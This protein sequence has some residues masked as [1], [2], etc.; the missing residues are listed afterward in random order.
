MIIIQ[1]ALSDVNICIFKTILALLVDNRSLCDTPEMKCTCH[2]LK[3]TVHKS[4]FRSFIAIFSDTTK[5]LHFPGLFQDF[6]DFQD[7][8]SFSR[9]FPGFP[10][11][12]GSVGTL[13]LSL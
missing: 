9:T 2:Y 1:L 4:T 3:R 12:P 6:Q 13:F 10:G 7:R 5:I 11:F 8:F